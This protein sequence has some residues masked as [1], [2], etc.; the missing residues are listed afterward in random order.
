MIERPE[1]L[2]HLRL[3]GYPPLAA[4]CGLAV[5]RGVDSTSCS[6]VRGTYG[7]SFY[8]GHNCTRYCDTCLGNHIIWWYACSCGTR[9]IIMW[10]CPTR[11]R[12]PSGGKGAA[13][14]RSRSVCVCDRRALQGFRILQNP[15]RI[16]VIINKH[17]AALGQTSTGEAAINPGGKP[18]PRLDRRP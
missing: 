9:L 5:H 12:A 11:E 10:K 16:H 15:R 7:N 18:P 2:P 8:G 14:L 17:M 13:T 4:C 6:L 3:T 1:G